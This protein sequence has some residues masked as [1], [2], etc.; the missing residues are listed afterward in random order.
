MG[1]IGSE[2]A[3]GR[4]D[5]DLV[6]D[7]RVLGE[8]SSSSTMGMFTVDAKGCFVA[9]SS[10]AVNITGYSPDELRGQPCQL[11]EGPQCKGFSGLTQLLEQSPPE[12]TGIEAQ[13]C[14]ILTKDSR[15][16][17]LLGSARLLVDS[18]GVTYGALAVFVDLTEVLAVNAPA[19]PSQAPRGLEGMIGESPPMEEVFRRVRLAADSDVTTLITG[20][21]G[22]GKELAAR[23][24]HKLSDRSAGPFIAVNCSALPESLLE[25][26]LFGHVKGAFTGA[27]QD[28]TGLFQSAEGGTLFL[29]EIG[30]ISPLLQ[31]KLLRV[32]QEREIQRVGDEH[33]IRVD[34]RLLTAT[35][36]DLQER[37]SA[38]QLREDFFYRI[39]V[40]DIH[41]P[42]LRE[43]A[44]DVVL[45]ADFFLQQAGKRHGRNDCTL[46]RDAVE[47]LVRYPW[48]GNV[49]EL[50]NAIEH[51]LV[52]QTGTTIGLLDLPEAVRGAQGHAA[53]GPTAR[54]TT[55]E[56]EAER[57]RILDALD[58]HGWNRT[59]T[60]ESLGISRVTL[61]KKIR[62]YQLDQGVFKRATRDELPG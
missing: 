37:L 12:R 31:L 38:G 1:S 29:D 60:A 15:V 46:A 4:Y 21:S 18:A 48:P 8:L 39:K 61:W 47:A 44:R 55:P 42:P 35:H 9:W 25:S 50:E 11:L 19:V 33:T 54:T 57:L 6:R 10:G 51:A 58:A 14:R 16:V 56:Q 62:R 59:R 5:L 7:S 22:T 41:L 43:R 49:R 40:F 34:V 26:E 32:L 30:D 27:T 53:S 17:H 36:R 28:R 24:I 13:E 52:I 45:L 3:Q 23:A 2:P 20:E